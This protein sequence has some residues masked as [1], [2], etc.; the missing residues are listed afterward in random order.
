M[1]SHG[2]TGGTDITGF[3]L[4]G[5]SL[6]MARNG[7]FGVRFESDKLPIYPEAPSL[8]ARGVRTGVTKANHD[9]AGPSTSFADRV[10]ETTRTLFFDPQTSGGLLFA[11]DSDKVDVA[12]TALRDQGYPE[13]AIVGEV[14]ESDTPRIQVV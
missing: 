14:F 6:E 3:G 10:D 1:R 13:A 11:V 2:V 9:N 7:G 4:A 8:I 5:H 12:V